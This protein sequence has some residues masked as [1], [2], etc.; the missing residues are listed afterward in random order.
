MNG[1]EKSKEIKSKDWD[2][3]VVNAVSC[4]CGHV[5]HRSRN[6]EMKTEFDES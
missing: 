2:N 3:I 6:K 5:T 4:A 1:K